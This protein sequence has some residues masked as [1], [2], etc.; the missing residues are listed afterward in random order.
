MTT[1]AQRAVA[2]SMKREQAAMKAAMT[3]TPALASKLEISS[4]EP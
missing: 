4:H 1:N 3:L 2:R